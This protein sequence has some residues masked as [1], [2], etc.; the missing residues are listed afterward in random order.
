MKRKITLLLL[1]I[2]ATAN[3]YSQNYTISFDASGTTNTLDSVRII[4]LTHPDTAIWHNGDVFQ[5]QLNNAINDIDANKENLLISPNPMQGKAEIMFNVKQAGIA[6][7]KIYEITGKEI[8]HSD[9]NLSQ[10]NHQFQLTGLKQGAYFINIR[11]NGYFYSSKLISYNSFSNDIN[12]KYNG[13]IQETN[14]NKY[15]TTNSSINFNFVS[16]DILQFTGYAANLTD[17]FTYSPTSDITVSFNFITSIPSVTTNAA[18]SITFNSA[19]CEG[20]VISDGGEIVTTRGICYA[21]TAN[22]STANTIITN[23]IGTGLFTADLTGLT[24]NTTYYLRAFAT[25]IV[26]TA[27][28]NEVSFTTTSVLPIL[29][30]DAV[31]LITFSSA[32]SG[33]HISIEGY[34]PIT[35]RGVCWSTSPNPHIGLSTKTNDGVDTGSFTSNIIGLTASTIYYVRA[36]ATNSFGTAYGNQVIFMTSPIGLPILTTTNVSSITSNSVAIGGDITSDGG[37]TITVRGIC[38]SSSPN[39]HIGLYN[40]NNGT[41]IGSFMDTIKN[42]TPGSTRFVRAFA[43]NSVGTAYGNEISFTTL[44]QDYDGNIYDIITIGN[45]VW[46]KQNLKTTHFNYGAA[47]NYPITNTAWQYASQ[48][49]TWYK[50][51]SATYKNTYGA[52]Y[53]GYAATNYICPD[54]WHVP[55]SAE[56]DTLTIYLG[57]NNIAGGKLKATALWSSPNIGATNSS[58]FSALPGGGRSADG[59]HYDTVSYYGNWWCSDQIGSYFC[60]VR[61]MYFDAGSVGSSVMEKH[62]GYSVRCLRNV[63]AQIVLP[64]I[65][66]TGA[67]NITTS[68]VISG[69]NILNTGNATITARGICWSTSPNPTIADS[70]VSAG[71]G[72]GIFTSSI[73]GLTAGTTYFVRAYATNS[74]GT[75]Y[76]NEISFTTLPSSLAVLTTTNVSS[77]SYTTVITGGNISSY[78]TGTIFARG[79]CWST[80]SNP[81]IA[82]NTKT[83]DGTGTGSFTSNISGLIPGTTYYVRAYATNSIGTAYGNEE[84]FTTIA[85][86]LPVLT[87]TSIS[88]IA[89]TTATSGGNISSDGGETVIARGVC[90]STSANPTI[91][92]SKTINGTGIGS[93]VSSITN[94]TANTTYY[95]RAYS[96]NNVGTAYGNEVS[97]TTVTPSLGAVIDYDGNVYDTVHIGTQV[98][99]KQNLKTTHYKIGTSIT[100]PGTNN[101]TWQYNTSGAYAWYNNDSVSNKI[102]YGALYNWYAVNTGNLCPTGWHVP[103]KADWI[104]LTNYLGGE[105]IAGGKLKA[106]TLWASP[107][108]GAT[109]ETGFTALPGGSRSNNGTFENYG[110]CIFWSSTEKET[111]SAWLSMLTYNNSNLYVSYTNK[112]SGRYVRCLRDIAVQANLPVLTTTIANST[113]AITG[114]SGGNISTDGGAAVTVRGVCWSIS[115]NPHIGLSTK[116]IDGSGV[117]SFTSSIIGL[118]PNTTYYVRTYATNSIGTSYGNELIFTTPSLIASKVY[119]IDGNTY[120]TIQIGYQIWLKQNLKTTHYKNGAA[121]AYATCPGNTAGSYCDFYKDTSYN[122]STIYGRLY[123]WYTVNT[124]SLCPTGWHVPSDQEWSALVTYLGNDST[125]GGKLKATTLWNSPNTGATNETGFTAL[126]GGQRDSYCWNSLLGSYGYWWSSTDDSGSNGWY[127]SLLYDNSKINR[128]KYP[129]SYYYSIRC[130]KDSFSLAY[131]PSVTTITASS[132][133]STTANSG[134]NITS[135]GGAVVTARGV[136]WSTTTNPTVALSTKTSDGTGIGSF[137][138]NITGL[139]AG[140][141]YYIRAYAIN[142]LGT[143]YGNEVSF[144]S[145]AIIPSLTTTAVT[146]IT[147]ATANLGGD[148]TSSGGEYVTSR[149]VCWST[150]ANPTIALSTKTNNGAGTGSFT[151]NITGLSAGTTYYVRAYA[152]NSIGTAY[153]NEVSFTTTVQPTSVIDYDGNGYDTIHIGTQIWMKQNLKTTHY[154]NG[155]TIIYPY[156]PAD[157]ST[158]TTGAYAWYNN[159]EATNKNIYGALYNWFAVNTG[160]L[161]PTGW[162][163]P[164]S[165]EWTTFLTYLG[166]DSIAGGKLKAINFWQSPNTGATNSSNFSALPCG[167]ISEF[168]GFNDLNLNGYWWS[169]T[170][171]DNSFSIGRC[172]SYNSNVVNTISIKKRY[173]L[174]V[175][176]IK[177]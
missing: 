43:T 54:G 130:I 143:A 139:T 48:A 40:T 93:F 50:N 23:G 124:D 141:T 9:E 161:C 79:V 137:I 150:S 30:T 119:D 78:G 28:G 166:G 112:I 95:V 158:S 86:S 133:A 26:G 12:L 144:T 24:P 156:Y 148:I 32:I 104:E 69:G 160:N 91:A 3:I 38:W 21:T 118:S 39:P 140:T 11:G 10:G 25:N 94:L 62:N 107:N 60:N 170:A 90:W 58:G 53:N 167:Y 103:T 157:W 171:F 116:T 106:T 146:N 4:N 175:R 76:G 19:T 113:T 81:T 105:S 174:S 56:W 61:N 163:V 45:Q 173:G 131:L 111:T 63:N 73:S 6:S 127:R 5:L 177:D 47:I 168:G 145:L 27:Y 162:H 114:I 55:T 97:F 67:T 109:N 22:P 2:F 65:I 37:A 51:D 29:T 88:A 121:I 80:S 33:G 7:I 41:G 147:S 165:A 142:S 99:M 135:I 87:T 34:S 101:T 108:T 126:P 149:G 57:G 1:I 100:Y 151:S 14:T 164:S 138:S 110:S 102:I 49:Y 176:C 68:T 169:S 77:I 59:T 8:I 35:E 46:M 128:N 66:S 123:D 13:I 75:A 71:T 82:L 15:K 96:T 64:T 120:D 84:S 92:N 154:K 153:G 172:I 125:S 122:S 42:L 20:N 152:T 98:W 155:A 17:V 74:I 83:S 132:I 16:G 72:T 159:E 36:Y 44:L 31:S 117:G 18:T 52:L 89:Y 136:C 134:G 70:I 115:P 85:V 129:K